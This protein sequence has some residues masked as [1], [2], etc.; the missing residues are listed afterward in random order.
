MEQEI[1]LNEASQTQKDERCTFSLIC[2]SWGKQS[3][4]TKVT[5]I[6]WGLLES[7][8]GK[9]KAREKKEIRKE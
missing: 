8:R 7:W 2:G 5:K 9:E 4:T 6:K 3:K 1:V